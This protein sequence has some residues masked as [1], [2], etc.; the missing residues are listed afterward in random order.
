M[1][2]QKLK[3]FLD[4][5]NVKYVSIKH[6]PAYTAHEVAQ[7]AHIPGDKIAKTVIVKTNSGDMVM[8]VMTAND[9]INFQHLETA[10]AGGRVEL[11]SEREFQD[12]FPGCEVGAM[13]PFGNL[14][15]M[16]VYVDDKLSQGNEIAFN[17]G[18]HAELIRMDYKDFERL[19]HPKPLH[20][21]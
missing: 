1:P 6:S 8:V 18:N 3:I 11:A 2:A 14:F 20:A 17:A 16:D 12:K 15:D 13:P 9:K 5:N 10:L 7:S 4:E 21:T 19:V